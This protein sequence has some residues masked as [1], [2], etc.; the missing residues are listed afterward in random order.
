M[1]TDL[2][3]LP[4][5]ISA[6]IGSGG[7]TSLIA[8][9]AEELAQKEKKVI[10]TTTTHIYPFPGMPLILTDGSGPARE[11]LSETLEKCPCVCIGSPSK[12]GKLTAPDIPPEELRAMADHV[13]IEADG[14]ARRPLKAHNQTE[15]VIPEGTGSIICVFGLS[16]FGHPI[17]EAVHRS[18]LFLDL[19]KKEYPSL[20]ETDLA[21][22]AMAARVFEKEASRLF[23]DKKSGAGVIFLNQA[24]LP[25][26]VSKADD[27]VS[28]L[29]N[30]PDLILAG[31]AAL[32]EVT[33]VYSV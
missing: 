19:L 32:R 29:V 16:G 4:G 17:G 23:T 15:P 8:A 3:P 1:L 26:A 22:P 24:D 20:T 25:G 30:K 14:A 10:V 5:G 28:S 12:D 7:K 9:C 33:K 18:G 11:N 6:F 13:L 2:L 31:S 21:A 27:F